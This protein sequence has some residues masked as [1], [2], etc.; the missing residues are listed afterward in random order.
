ANSGKISGTVSHGGSSYTLD[1][2][3][4]NGDSFAVTPG[5]RSELGPNQ[6]IELVDGVAYVEQPDGTWLRY[7]S[8]SGVGPKVGPQ[9]EL[10]HNNVAGTTAGQI[11][12]LATGLTQTSQSDGTILYTG[13]IPNLDTDP[14][15]APTDDTILRIITDLRTG[16]LAG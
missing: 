4:W 2:T 12:S 16:K 7:A 1:M 10:A 6:A 15:V 13:M 9:F 8:E 11:L 5:D 3:Q 14:G